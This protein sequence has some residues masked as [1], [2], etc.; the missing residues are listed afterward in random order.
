[1]KLELRK[2]S[3]GTS[4]YSFVYYDRITKKPKRITQSDIRKR[5]GKSIVEYERAV[6]ASK[7]LE[8]EQDSLKHRIEKRVV[9]ENEFYEFG[10]LLT[11]YEGQQQKK[12]PNSY[13]NNLHY[14][15][16]Y[17]LSFFLSKKKCNN[18]SMW[19]DF[20]P[21]FKDW[22]EDEARLVKRPEQAISFA[23]KNHAI[24]A[25][26][27]FMHSLF[28]RG[29]IERYFKCEGFPSHTLNEKGI[30]DIIQPDEM[31]S[32]YKKLKQENWA[33]EAI[34]FRFLYFTGMRFN[35]ALGVHPGNLY[36]GEI[37][38]RVLKK[39]LLQ[40]RFTY[41]G[42]VVID[43]QPAHATRGL[44]DENGRINRKPLKGRRKIDDKSARTVIIIDKILWNELV[45][46]HNEKLVL[47]EGGSFGRE[48]DQYPLFEG[49]DKS[50]STRKLIFAFEKCGLK[51]RSW[52]CCRHTRATM[53]IG[54]TSNSLLARLWLGHSSE[55]VLSRYVHIYEAVVRSAKKN[56]SESNPNFRRLKQVE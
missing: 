28:R 46:L 36:E 12:A 47:L 32:I 2:N 1:M 25:L 7:L 29:V 21:E 26:N 56:I 35:E 22:L 9:W 38:D 31:E 5:F 55:K 3:D 44:R 4:Y 14:L 40:E 16:Y 42:Y 30:G 49:I 20:Y 33:I 18:L 17:V 8:A 37:E 6:E 45:N 13:K 50:S 52:H 54:E 51:Y 43:S 48:V 24:K 39:H 34:F 11:F 15:K 19:F 27:T 41:W 10:K 53:L 23:S